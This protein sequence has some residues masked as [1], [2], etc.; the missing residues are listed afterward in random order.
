MHIYLC[1]AKVPLKL[2]LVFHFI[3]SFVFM[4]LGLK[5]SSVDNCLKR[6]FS[7]DCLFTIGLIRTMDGAFGWEVYHRITGAIVTL[8]LPCVI[9]TIVGVKFACSD[10]EKFEFRSTKVKIAGRRV[11]Q[12][13]N[14]KEKSK[15]KKDQKEM[16]YSETTKSLHEKAINSSALVQG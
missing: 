14:H 1:E 6:R 16:S 9:I 15:R 7:Y 13:R 4:C 5:E 11:M 12:L 8:L 10:V 3:H 2:A